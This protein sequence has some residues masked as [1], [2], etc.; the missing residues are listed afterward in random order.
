[1]QD[2]TN[3]RGLLLLVFLTCLTCVAGA[4]EVQVLAEEEVYAFVSPDNGSGPM[5]AYGSTEIARADDR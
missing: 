4:V 3:K 2:S 1:M 5:W